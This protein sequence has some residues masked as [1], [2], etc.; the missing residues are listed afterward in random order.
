VSLV[1]V[2]DQRLSLWQSAVAETAAKIMKEAGAA[3]SRREEILGHPWVQ[4]TSRFVQTRLTKTDQREGLSALAADGVDADEALT[5]MSSLLFDICNA[6]L[7]GRFEDEQKLRDS[8]WPFSN[9]DPNFASCEKTYLYYYAATGGR[10]LYNDWTIQGKFNLNYGVIEWTIPNNGVVGIIG[11]WGTGMSDAKA[12][13]QAMVD[14]PNLAAIIHVGDIYYSGTPTEC[15]AYFSEIFYEVFGTG[16]GVP[17]FTLPGNH[18]YYALGYGFF[19]ML[20]LLNLGIPTASQKASYFCLRTEDNGWQFLGMD[21]GFNDSNPANQF[22]PLYAGPQLVSSEILWHRDKLENFQGAT[23]LLSHHQVY[24]ANAKINGSTSDFSELPNVNPYLLNTFQPYFKDRVAAWIWGHEHNFVLYQN[25]LFGLA[26]GRLLGASAYEEM[27]EDDPYK[28]IYPDVPYLDPSKYQLPLQKNGYYPHSYGLIDFSVRKNPTDPVQVSYYQFPSWYPTAPPNPTPSLIYQETFSKPVPTP[29]EP[30]VSK[31]PIMLSIEGGL[32][33]ISTAYKG[34]AE[35][36]PTVGTSPAVLKLQ[37]ITR[38]DIVKSGD[39]VWILSTDTS[40]GYY[41]YL[42]VP[43]THWLYWESGGFSAESFTITKLD[44]SVDDVIRYG[45]A[46]MFESQY[47]PGQFIC[48]TGDG[49]LTTTKVTPAVTFVVHK[50][51]VE[52]ESAV[53][54][55]NQQETVS[56][57]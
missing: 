18:D 23:I 39:T 51:I 41:N 20:P 48:P 27:K 43:T 29:Q 42:Y 16:S 24:S 11:D 31:A 19:T 4:A 34:I 17:V 8:Y 28:V 14:T 6:R 49:Y 35:N 52:S 12:L 5:A 1:R 54:V 47:Y 53:V 13:L 3:P 44:L 37:D 9:K 22:N 55:T 32:N 36:Y 21:T 38:N 2:H 40:L 30:V 45:D 10:F 33:Y 7:E 25:N 57:S 46:V 50:G 26:K 56:S 15:S